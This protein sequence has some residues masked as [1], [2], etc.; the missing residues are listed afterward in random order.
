MV[1]VLPLAAILLAALL[2]IGGISS[3]V[4]VLVDFFV[5]DKKKSE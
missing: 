4:T 2:L 1:D 5:S 3:L